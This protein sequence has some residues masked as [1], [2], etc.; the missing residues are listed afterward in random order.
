[1]TLYLSLDS[2]TITFDQD[3]IGLVPYGVCVYYYAMPLAREGNQV[4]V[5]MA[6][7]D[8]KTAIS[9][10][11]YLLAAQVVPVRGSAEA[12]LA[13]IGRWHP[14]ENG[15]EPKVLAWSASPET[16]A[17]V[18]DLAGIFSQLSGHSL[19]LL[20]SPSLSLDTVL[21]TARTG[22][23]SLTVLNLPQTEVAYVLEHSAT[24]LLLV[25]GSYSQL[26]RILIVWRGFSS[27]GYALNWMIP[28]ARQLE[29][30]VCVMPLTEPPTRS[31]VGLLHANGL[32]KQHIEEC[33]HRLEAEGIQPYLKLREGDPVNQVATELAQGD[34][35]LLVIAAEG[36][37]H[38]VAQVLTALAERHAHSDRPVFILKPPFIK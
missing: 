16:A 2:N 18:T 13:A 34:Y 27:D 24:P 14:G 15:I 26:R 7:P 38:F 8:N 12:I 29:C 5:W 31:L 11:G 3:L 20:D 22:R 21:T 35:D 1:M 37:G 33:L 23:Y 25:P 4:S 9:V 36:Q 19:A 28:L 10:L 30:N 32:V 6:Y 17:A